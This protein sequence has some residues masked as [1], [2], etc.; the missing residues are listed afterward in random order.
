LQHRGR[1]DKYKNNSQ[2]NGKGM[3]R[4]SLKLKNGK[5]LRKEFK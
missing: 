1:L 5:E 2:I 3:F 4:I